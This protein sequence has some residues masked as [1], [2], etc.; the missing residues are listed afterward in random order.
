[1]L[2]GELQSNEFPE[3]GIYSHEYIPF[4]SEVQRDRGKILDQHVEI[5]EKRM[6]QEQKKSWKREKTKLVMKKK[7]GQ[8]SG[9]FI[10]PYVY[11][12]LEC[13]GQ[14]RVPIEDVNPDIM[15]WIPPGK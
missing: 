9:V 5:M 1:M 7:S 15:V 6:K 13:K 11:W 10:Q 4:F 8:D 14:E 12:T 3:G 2:S